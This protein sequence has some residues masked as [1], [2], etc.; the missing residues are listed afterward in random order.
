MQKVAVVSGD[1][2]LVYKL[3]QLLFLPV[4]DPFHAKELTFVVPKLC[5]K[6]R[7]LIQLGPLILC[8]VLKLL[9]VEFIERCA[10]VFDI[11]L[12]ELF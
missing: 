4:D 12:L 7:Y 3:L 8:P 2:L 5:E 1:K 11:G 9:Q 6:L 10:E